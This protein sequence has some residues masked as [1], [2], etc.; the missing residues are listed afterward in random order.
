MTRVGKATPP[1]YSMSS[2]PK[3]FS[4]CTLLHDNSI[5]CVTI[6]LRHPYKYVNETFFG[7]TL[8]SE[9]YRFLISTTQK[10]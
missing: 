10:F 4:K 1:A 6:E 9:D 3:P 2:R 7:I 8:V 5:Q